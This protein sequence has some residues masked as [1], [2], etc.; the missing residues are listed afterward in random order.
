MAGMFDGQKTTIASSTSLVIG[1]V[2]TL[3]TVSAQFVVG[4]FQGILVG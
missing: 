1:G 3:S 4:G 2:G